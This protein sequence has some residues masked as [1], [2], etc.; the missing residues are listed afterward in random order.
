M[1]NMNAAVE[2]A[3]GETLVEALCSLIDTNKQNGLT[4]LVESALMTNGSSLS[5]ADEATTLL[6][7]YE[8]VKGVL[9]KG[10]AAVDS[11]IS[12]TRQSQA[13]QDARS[14]ISA[15][16]VLTLPD[17]SFMEPRGRFRM[18]VSKT[19]IF[20]E[21]KNQSFL[22]P[23]SKISH[24]SCVPSNASL[25]KEGEDFFSIR[26]SEPIANN[27]KEGSGL[28]CTLGKNVAKQISSAD[29][30][31]GIESDIVTK[32]F[33]SV[34]S[35]I[36]IIRPQSLLFMSILQRKPF[37][38]CYK[39]TQEGVIYPLENGVLFI[40]P[41]LF[42]PA[43][44]IASL[45]AGRG[46]S[47]GNTRYVDLKIDTVSG[48]EYEFT[49]IDRDELP[50]LQLYVKGYLEAMQRKKA[51][52]GEAKDE[53]E[54]EDEKRDKGNEEESG[55]GASANA[56]TGFND[57][58]DDDDSDEDDDDYDPDA[59]D[60]DD[61]SGSD[62]ESSSEDDH[63]TVS[64]RSGG[65]GD[66]HISKV[67]GKKRKKLSKKEKAK[68][69]KQSKK[70]KKKKKKKR[71]RTDED[72]GGEGVEQ[73]AGGE[74]EKKSSKKKKL[75]NK[76][77]E[78]S[79]ENNSSACVA[80]SNRAMSTSISTDCV[81]GAENKEV[82]N[83]DTD[84]TACATAT[85]TATASVAIKTISPVAADSIVVVKEE[86]SLVKVE[87]TV[88]SSVSPCSLSAG[89]D[90]HLT[91]VGGFAVPSSSSLVPVDPTL[92]ATAAAPSSGNGGGRQKAQPKKHFSATDSATTNANTNTAATTTTTTT[93][94]ATAEALSSVLVP[95]HVKTTSSGST[96]PG[97]PAPRQKTLQSFFSSGG[98]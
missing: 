12:Q 78:L 96:A 74:E 35:E 33:Q 84:T 86:I 63:C 75:K 68:L 90:V 30:D 55:D 13:R 3:N 57:V 36:S 41:S 27:G 14:S 83:T 17:L 4:A 72:E 43:E 87:P 70:D 25:K 7:K 47:A 73:G 56:V 28:L 95:V 39:G 82:V 81:A 37:L 64:D 6:A 88:A 26:F 60:S 93:T 31:H 45:I 44:E 15:D 51:L 59:S 54:D 5:S 98:K 80:G 48:P 97:A 24:M 29:G 94:A 62:D 61:E 19:S 34:V 67:K 8:A 2:A 79:N 85:A 1:E 53:D 76:T 91:E 77:K 52:A 21:G 65:E 92:A 16:V 58:D 9:L 71:K 10:I 20:L 89:V 46:G 50:S 66:R 11:V 22:Y 49:N 69:L 23:L 38:R 40:K 32:V 18:V 42:I